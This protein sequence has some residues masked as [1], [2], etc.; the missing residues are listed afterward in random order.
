MLHGERTVKVKRHGIIYKKRNPVAQEVR[1]EKYKSQVIP[2]RH[3]DRKEEDKWKE[4]INYLR[5]LS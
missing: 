4:M 1:T 3:K 5:S 2:D